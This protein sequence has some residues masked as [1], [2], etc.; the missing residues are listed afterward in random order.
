L[1]TIILAATGIFAAPARSGAPPPP[2][3]GCLGDV[4]GNRYV[5]SLDLLLT[6]L[7]YG[8]SDPLY[9]F[10]NDAVV[11]SGDLLMAALRFG[12]CSYS[13][14]LSDLPTTGTPT[15]GFGPFERDRS[16]GENGAGDGGPLTINGAVFAKGLGVHAAADLAF[17]VPSN[18][19]KFAAQVGIDDE[20]ASNVGSVAFEVWN[21]TTARLYQSPV[22]TGA[23]PATAIDLGLAGVS[24]L[25][26][27]AVPGANDAFDH[28]DW[29]D[30]KLT[31]TGGD[32]T[33]PLISAL[34]ATP[35]ATAATIA[36]TTNEVADTQVE[37][38]LTTGYGATATNSMLVA[39]H[40]LGLN[41]L[42]PGTTYHYRVK[43]RDPA[44]NIQASA[45][46]TFTTTASLFG[47][48]GA[49]AAGT[50]AHAV[51]VADL[52]ADTKM[53]L[54]TANAG[55]ATISVLIG[56]GAGG[57]AAPVAYATGSQPKNVVLGHLNGDAFLDAVTANQG[58]SNVSVLLGAAGGTFLA[59]TDVAACTNAHEATLALLNADAFLDIACVGW[60]A[61]QMRVLLGNGAGGFAAAVAYTAGS[62][63]HSIV[64]GDFNGDNIRDLATANHDS[65]N[66]SVFIGSGTGTFAAHVT[67][68]AGGNGPHSIRAADLNGDG[69][70]DLVTA[71][72][73]SDNIGIFYGNPGAGI[74]TFQ[75]VVNITV[76]N[77]PKGIALAD[78]NGDTKLDILTAN[79]NDNYPTLINPGGDTIS[80]LL[81]NGLG[82]FQ[83][84]APYTVGQ[85]PFAVAVGNFNADAKLDIA[86]ANWWDNAVTVRLN[87]GP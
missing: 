85:A 12:P 69:D 9:D 36:W 76:G 74:G 62:A 59:K 48:P 38:G 61:A 47:P 58:T 31:C 81:G 77:T 79:I 68:A 78:I 27:V 45:D 8:T 14:F 17:A 20:V 87:T 28:A 22:K 4:D 44:G 53:D 24:T 41:G 35:V 66:I 49:F 3:P 32:F 42:T 21:G 73:Q 6:V 46:Q 82:V 1:P 18:C 65:A 80:V 16:N 51:A 60:G 55:A 86:T 10:N 19:T 15:N 52:N 40:S 29:A 26:L 75:A 33:K 23:D 7:H 39:N 70:L 63:P 43:S 67:Y 11:N 54:V 72:N 25:R 50:S 84:A 30:A 64:A 5:N 71:N 57:F 37:Y 83:P 34:M 13:I 56:D 2:V